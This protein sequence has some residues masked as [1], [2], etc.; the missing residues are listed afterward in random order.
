MASSNAP[1]RGV[2]EKN[3]Q[4]V[5]HNKILRDEKQRDSF[6]W[7]SAPGALLQEISRDERERAILRSRRM[8]ET[9]RISDL[10]TA[11]E[12]G[13]IKGRAEAKS[14]IITL[15]K[16]GISLEEIEKTLTTK[17]TTFGL[18]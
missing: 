7:N 5:A 11:E 18:N 6:S 16:Q 17:N 13:M 4:D 14:E 12:R 9:D 8:A 15:L 1:R 3:V 10:L 2:D